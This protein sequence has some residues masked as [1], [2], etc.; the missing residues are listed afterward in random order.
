MKRGQSKDALIYASKNDFDLGV[1]ISSS[2]DSEFLDTVDDDKYLK[3]V[4]FSVLQC[5]NDVVVPNITQCP[6]SVTPASLVSPSKLRKSRSLSSVNEFHIG[7]TEIFVT[8]IVSRQA[9]KI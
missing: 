8:K 4:N 3:A 6:D 7:S 5:I 1:N 2:D 9:Y